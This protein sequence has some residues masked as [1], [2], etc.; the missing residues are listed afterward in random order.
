MALTAKQ[1]HKLTTPG[2][3]HD[4]GGLYFQVTSSTNRGWLFRYQRRGH[5]RW[6]G[7]GSAREF[8]LGEA[9]ERA[10]AARQ[11]LRDG[12]DPIDAR[13]VEQVAKA[14]A[15]TFKKAALAY[16]KA[17]QRNWRNA[18]YRVQFLSTLE[19]Y[20]F[21]KIGA[22][23]I[24]AVDDSLVFEVIEP[25][26][27]AKTKIAN[28][29][30]AQIESVLKWTTIQGYRNGVSPAVL[31]KHRGL[32]PRPHPPFARPYRGHAAIMG[33]RAQGDNDRRKANPSIPNTAA[34]RREVLDAAAAIGQHL[35]AVGGGAES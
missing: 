23:P 15:L 1:V 9:R 29:L 32:S 11:K 22:L 16:F 10:N 24:A 35:V 33:T 18:N 28:N 20:I 17:H 12:I 2:R 6:M 27:L 19:A 34:E 7:L 8:D 14:R 31:E 30:R 4:G 5:A 3:Y 25:I 26:R 13:K 21:P